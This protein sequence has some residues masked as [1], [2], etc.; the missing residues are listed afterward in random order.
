MSMRDDELE[1]IFLDR[2]IL[3]GKPVVRGTRIPVYL[4]LDLLASGMSQDEVLKEYPTIKPEDIRACLA[5]A[6][7]RLSQ[8]LSK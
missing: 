1:R 2:D 8:S 7:L 3:A 4:I 6:S 5:Y